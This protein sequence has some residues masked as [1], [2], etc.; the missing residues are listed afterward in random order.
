[1]SFVSLVIKMLLDS[2]I[3]F[4]LSVRGNAYICYGK[5]DGENFM[6]NIGKEVFFEK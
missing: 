1:M 3:F 6:N 5:I 2:I 4:V